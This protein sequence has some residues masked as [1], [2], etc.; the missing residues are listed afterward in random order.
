MIN[1]LNID[2]RNISKYLILAKN[3]IPSYLRC[4]ADKEENAVCI[5]KNFIITSFSNLGECY[6][7]SLSRYPINETN[8]FVSD[9]KIFINIYRVIQHKSYIH[10]SML[11]HDPN[12][13]P[14]LTFTDDFS[15]DY[16]MIKVERLPPPYDSNCFDY[17]NSINKSFK[18]HGQCINDCVFKQ[19]LKKYDCIPRE[20]VNVLTLYDNMTLDL[21]FCVDKNF[22]DFSEDDCSDRCPKPCEE[23]FYISRVGPYNVGQIN[24]IKNHIYT[25]EIY[26]TI[27]VFMSSIGGLL[28]LWNNVSVYDLELIIIK[29]CEKIFKMKLLTKLL[30]RFLSA[31]ILKSF[32]LIRSFVV[33]SNLKVK[34]YLLKKFYFKFI[35]FLFLGSSNDFN[36]YYSHNTNNFIHLRFPFVQKSLGNQNTKSY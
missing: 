28:G 3:E 19:I 20:S 25:N 22:D 9:L 14:P 31:K 32:D 6:T 17:E 5:E 2:E 15:R 29:Y 8:K 10:T 16:S 13:L 30:K 11:F 27:I 33:K 35:L 23:S 34:T 36:G 18:T 4:A 26:M 7:L 12:E 24:L 1:G 21:T